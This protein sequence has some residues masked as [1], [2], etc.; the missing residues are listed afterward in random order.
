MTEIVNA[1]MI[2]LWL[3]FLMGDGCG[4]LFNGTLN[5]SIINC[6]QCSW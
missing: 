6:W 4:N 3:G 5:G 1:G 2:H